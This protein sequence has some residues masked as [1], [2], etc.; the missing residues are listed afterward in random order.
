[1]CPL[2]SSSVEKSEAVS[3]YSGEPSAGEVY[4]LNLLLNLNQCNIFASVC[5]CVKVC[6]VCV[7]ILSS[8]LVRIAVEQ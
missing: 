7:F 1:M 2:T 3:R 5:V 6:V 4:M 8:C